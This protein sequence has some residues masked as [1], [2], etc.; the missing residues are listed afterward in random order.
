MPFSAASEDFDEPVRDELVFALFELPEGKAE[1]I[2]S[3]DGDGGCRVTGWEPAEHRIASAHA[4]GARAHAADAHGPRIRKLLHHL[5][6]CDLQLGRIDLPAVVRRHV[7]QSLRVEL[8]RQCGHAELLHRIGNHLGALV[9]HLER[10][11]RSPG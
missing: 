4:A 10:R 9:V 2:G 7:A 11:R 6:P 5:R 3:V 1:V 8:A